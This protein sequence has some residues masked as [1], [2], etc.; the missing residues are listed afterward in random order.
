MY[1]GFKL[2]LGKKKQADHFCSEQQVLG[3]LV[4]SLKLARANLSLSKSQV[5]VTMQTYTKLNFLSTFNVFSKP[6]ILFVRN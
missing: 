5:S 4:H 3:Q 2:K 6:C 1:Q